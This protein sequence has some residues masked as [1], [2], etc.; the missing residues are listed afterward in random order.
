MS[1]RLY[2]DVHVRRAVADGLRLRGVDVLTAQEDETA[3]LEDSRLLDRATQLGRLLFTQDKDFL[4]EASRRLGAGE[5]LFGI[6]YAHQ[7]RVSI[8]QCITDLEMIAKNS[9]PDEWIDRVE[10]LP[11]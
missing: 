5:V 6:V 7:L 3:E 4:R 10:H 1:V 8:G 11:L 2:F 9:E